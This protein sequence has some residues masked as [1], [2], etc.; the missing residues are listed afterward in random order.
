MS[1][2]GRDVQLG[3]LFNFDQPNYLNKLVCHS[4]KAKIP[5][6]VGAIAL[7]GMGLGLGIVWVISILDL[8]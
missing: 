5:K 1:V 7:A 4:R 8:L 2:G 6:A 3:R